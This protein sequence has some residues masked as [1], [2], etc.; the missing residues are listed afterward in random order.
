M[1]RSQPRPQGGV[2]DSWDLV[3][4]RY[5]KNLY[6]RRI[7]PEVQPLTVLYTIYD[8]KGAPFVYRPIIVFKSVLVTIPVLRQH[9]A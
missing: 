1:S 4:G 9:V 3:P 7:R 5:S 2:D 6:T 8:E